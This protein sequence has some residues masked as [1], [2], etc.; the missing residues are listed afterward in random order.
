MHLVIGT[1]SV[2]ES[3]A[4]RDGDERGSSRRHRWSAVP[5]PGARID[6]EAGIDLS[7]VSALLAPRVT[8]P[9]HRRCGARAG[10]AERLECAGPTEMHLSAVESESRSVR[11]RWRPA[12]GGSRRG[13]NRE[14]SPG[15]RMKRLDLPER[16]EASDRRKFAGIQGP[17]PHPWAQPFP[18]NCNILLYC[19][20]KG[21][22]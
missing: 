12:D 14:Q 22:L 4:R 18:A 8:L 11:R 9:D 7:S 5:G 10:R 3:G 2:R 19:S 20:R 16:V 21:S 17:A 13:M 15:H 1:K 6:R